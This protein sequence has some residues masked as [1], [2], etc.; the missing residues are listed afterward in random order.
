MSRYL[1][2]QVSIC[3]SN[4]VHIMLRYKCKI[5]VKMQFKIMSE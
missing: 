1:A 5:N 4:D 3:Q 2:M